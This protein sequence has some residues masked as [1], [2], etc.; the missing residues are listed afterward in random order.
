MYRQTSAGV[1]K[2]Q[3]T[4]D[5]EATGSAVSPHLRGE[6][7]VERNIAM[8]K[9]IALMSMSLDGY[10]ADS[11]DGV[12]EV[13]DW[14]FSGEVEI[15]MPVATSEFTFRVSPQSADH[16]RGLMA[17]VGAFLTGRRTFD[18]AHGWEGQHPWNVPAFV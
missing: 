6:S 13:F 5:S 1:R 2:M 17:E 11:D 7:S 15:L 12:V 9:V 4:S 8:S 14:Y 18:A 10:V 3:Q 16:V